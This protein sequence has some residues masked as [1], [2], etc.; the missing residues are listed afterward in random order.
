VAIAN[1]LQLTAA[2]AAVLF[3]FSYDTHAKFE[4]TQPICCRL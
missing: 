1:A 4:V 3:L 2:R